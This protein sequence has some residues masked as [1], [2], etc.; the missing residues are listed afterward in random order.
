MSWRSRSPGRRRKSATT[1]KCG[2]RY[3][4]TPRD[5]GRRSSGQPEPIG[6]SAVRYTL[7]FCRK[8]LP[9]AN[10][11]IRTKVERL[12]GLDVEGFVPRVGVADGRGA[13]LRRGVRVREDLA[14]ECGLAGLRSPVLAK[15]D[16]ELLVAGES[17][18]RG[19][20][21]PL[22]R[23]AIAVVGCGDA[24][25]V[26]DVFVDRLLAVHMDAGEKLIRVV[27]LLEFLGLLV[28]VGEIFGRP[29]VAD[30]AFRVEGAS[31]RVESVADLVA[32]DGADGSVV[33][34]CRRFGVEEGRLQNGGREVQRIVQR[35]VDG[36]DGLR[37]HAPLVAIDGL[38]HASDL[39]L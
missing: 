22:K 14:A 39:R 29:P 11:V 19:A 31:F 7:S 23:G 9:D 17:V 16:E 3:C 26:G 20:F 24:A 5:C 13:E 38:A 27:L 6:C 4:S 21:L 32:D 30:A 35:H 1:R 8:T 10:A 2:K 18:L 33:R 15:G 28:E 12:S 36:V 34:G 25:E 37:F